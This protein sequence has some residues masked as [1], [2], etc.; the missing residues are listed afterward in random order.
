M[1]RK[2]RVFF[3]PV[4]SLW[5]TNRL[6][7]GWLTQFLL[8]LMTTF[9]C[10][11]LSLVFTKTT[12][13]YSAVPSG[14]KA[15]AFTQNLVQQGKIFYDAGQFAQAVKVL[16]QAATAFEANGDELNQAIALSNLSLTY[17]QLG[18][19]QAESAIASSLNLSIYYNPSKTSA[20]PTSNCKSL[21]K[22]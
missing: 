22:P 9:L 6:G 5:K 2:R 8:V 17:Q 12:A 21:P 20:L 4:L 3:N 11:T 15:I 1:I 18:L 13:V 16:Q 19:P 14:Q 7:K 10:I